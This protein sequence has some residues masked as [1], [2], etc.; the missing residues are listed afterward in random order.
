MVLRQPKPANIS[1]TARRAQPAGPPPTQPTT[2]LP[3]R[4]PPKARNFVTPLLTTRSP[5]QLPSGATGNFR[6][7]RAPR[8]DQRAAQPSIA[9]AVMIASE[10]LDLE[11]GGRIQR[12]RPGVVGPDLKRDLV[13]A[14]GPSVLLNRLQQR[15]SAPAAARWRED[16]HPQRQHAGSRPPAPP[17]ARPPGRRRPRAP[18]ARP[19]RRAR[20]ARGSA[21]RDLRRRPAAARRGSPRARPRR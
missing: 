15:A 9:A 17:R 16:R 14:A 6:P 20:S 3:P 2:P 10:A 5:Y 13:G 21:R 1:L 19:D 8:H 18:R 11:A 7:I 12:D 4:P